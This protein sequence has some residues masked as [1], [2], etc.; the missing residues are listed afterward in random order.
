MVGKTATAILLVFF[1][2]NGASAI[3]NGSIIFV[4]MASSN[5][6]AW[7]ATIYIT[8]LGG[9]SDN[10][11]FG[12]AS[13]ALDSQD[14]YDIPE[15]P[16]PFQLPYV[17]ARF[18]T[19]INEPYNNLWHEYKQYPDD[20]KVWNL[21]IQWVPEPGNESSATLIISWNKDEVGSSEYDSIII[22][23]NNSIVVD[24]KA[25]SS[26]TVNTAGGI[27]HSYQIVCQGKT[28]DNNKT[29]FVPLFLVLI[30]IILFTLNYKKRGKM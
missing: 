18:D 17:I 2:F 28:S 5:N 4:T 30:S 12:E 14:D 26:Y 24:M 22:Y 29:P 6:I 27:I 8:E 21:S 15:P 23:Q 11:V 1:I 10:V 16:F 3:Y 13:D 19:S 7:N 25:E 20:Y 9:I